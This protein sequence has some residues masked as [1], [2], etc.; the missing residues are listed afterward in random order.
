MAKAK[1]KLDT[2]GMAAVL[3]SPE[4]EAM[5]MEA[6]RAVAAAAR[7]PK[8]STGEVRV[9]VERYT[10][11]G[12]RLASPRPAAAVVAKHPSAIGMEAKHGV[13]VRAASSV[14]PVKRRGAK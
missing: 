3:N 8:P 1:V 6:A 13:L 5:V 4:V 11:R 2:A 7:Y 10:A 12:G 14:A 9:E